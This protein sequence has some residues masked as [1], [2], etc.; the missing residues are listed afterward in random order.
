MQR[1]RGMSDEAIRRALGLSR[2]Q[3]AEAGLLRREDAA[4]DDPE[5]VAEDES[6]GGGQA[7]WAGR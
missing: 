4:A 7:E 1:A 2:T 5:R 3:V 6:D